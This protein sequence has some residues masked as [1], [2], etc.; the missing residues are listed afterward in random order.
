MVLEAFPAPK[1]LSLIL[2]TADIHTRFLVQC[3]GSGM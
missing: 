2:G 1:F 3:W